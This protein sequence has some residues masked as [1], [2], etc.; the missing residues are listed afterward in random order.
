MRMSIN[1]GV[2]CIYYNTCR[3]LCVYII[4]ELNNLN[5]GNLF[6]NFN[7]HG[8]FIKLYGLFSKA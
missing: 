4:Y 2:T 6:R 7:G 3:S 5:N 8:R 1:T